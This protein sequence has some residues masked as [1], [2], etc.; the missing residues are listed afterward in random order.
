MLRHSI[1]LVLIFSVVCMQGC[2]QIDEEWTWE[3]WLNEVSIKG[4]FSSDETAA[5]EDFASF[6]LL[7]ADMYEKDQLLSS[8]MVLYTYEM[9]L[10]QKKLSDL[11]EF[12][13]KDQRLSNHEAIQALTWLTSKLN[14]IGSDSKADVIYREVPV[15]V[16]VLSVK[17]NWILVDQPVVEGQL[18][19]IEDKVYRVEKTDQD[20][21]VVEEATM[22]DVKEMDLEGT[23][24][25]HPDSSILIVKD[26]I[27]ELNEMPSAGISTNKLSKSFEVKGFQVRIST[28]DDSM[29]IYASKKMNSGVPVFVQFDI[30]EITCGFKW[31]KREDEVVASALKV[32]YETSLTSGLRAIDYEDRSLDFSKVDSSNFMDS[33]KEAFVKKQDCLEDTIELAEIQLPFPEFPACTLNMKVLL[34]LYASGKAEIAFESTHEIGFEMMNGKMRWIKECEKESHLALR[35]SAKASTKLQFALSVLSKDCMDASLELGLQGTCITKMLCDDGQKTLAEIPYEF[36][37][38]ASLSNDELKVCADLDAYWLMNL[39]FNSNKTVLG[40]LGFDHTFELL[41]SSNAS[42]FGKTVHLENFQ[43]VERCTRNA[44]DDSELH[45]N[46]NTDRI[47]LKR[48]LLILEEGNSELIEITGFPE[49]YSLKD[50][51][52]Q[53]A[54]TEI[55]SVTSSGRVKAKLEGETIIT[56]SSKDGLYESQCSIFV[57]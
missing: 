37:E 41:N 3:K 46:L 48:Y 19:W 25:F 5:I 12:L 32:S 36:A 21:I 22:D 15:Q 56:I 9:L 14:E 30:N 34:H 4:G 50:L 44:S 31:K 45:V 39:G 33:L 49:G 51:I 2:V 23:I 6:E 20:W 16:K 1:K 35:A 27:V 29:H 10:D 8:F 57:K 13:K 38:E 11:P 7:D 42:L 17:D 55:A 43:I 26:E 53:S 18:V 40:S 28:S 24:S 54:D 47:E 52:Y